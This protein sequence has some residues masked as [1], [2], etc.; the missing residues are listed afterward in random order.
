M[1]EVSVFIFP[2]TNE[3]LHINNIYYFKSINFSIQNWHIGEW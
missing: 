3:P 2:E 1:F